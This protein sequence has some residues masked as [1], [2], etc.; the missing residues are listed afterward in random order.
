MCTDFDHATG[1]QVLV[2]EVKIAQ[3][4]KSFVQR[5]SLLILCFLIVG[6]RLHLE[7]VITSLDV[8]YLFYF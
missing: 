8:P 3:A 1:A 7:I 5:I 4:F 2:I 6:V